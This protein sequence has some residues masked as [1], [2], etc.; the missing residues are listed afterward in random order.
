MRFSIVKTPVVDVLANISLIEHEIE[1]YE[2]RRIFGLGDFRFDIT[3]RSLGYLRQSILTIG[4]TARS[5]SA[6]AQISYKTHHARRP[7]RKCL[8]DVL[9]PIIAEIERIIPGRKLIF[10]VTETARCAASL[11]DPADH[12]LLNLLFSQKEAQVV[13]SRF[14]GSKL[15][16]PFLEGGVLTQEGPG[17]PGLGDAEADLIS[18]LYSGLSRHL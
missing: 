15:H 17:Q 5:F 8:V 12:P 6:I 2:K 16:G 9:P 11:M 10:S 13:K 3:R 14:A 1:R 4:N 7:T 18:F